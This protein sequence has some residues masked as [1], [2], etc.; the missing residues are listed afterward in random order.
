LKLKNH[1]VNRQEIIGYLYALGATAIWSGNVAIARGLFNDIPPVSLAFWRWVVAVIVTLPFGLKWLIAE[2]KLLIKHLPYLMFTALLGITLFNTLL[3]IAGHTTTAINLSLISITFPI[4][5]IL[6][7]RIFFQEQITLN[8][9][10]GIILVVSGI[11]LLITKG[12]PAKL[13]DITF[14]V[15]DVLMLIAAFV[16]ALYGIKIKQKP[17]EMNM[18]TFQFSTF[19]LGLIFLLPAYAWEY[20]TV[21]PVMFTPRIVAAI[22]YIGIFASL[23][24]FILWNKAIETIGPSKTGLAYYSM[25]LFGGTLAFLFLKEEISILHLYCVLLIVAGILI[26]NYEKRRPAESEIP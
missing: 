7:S 12:N 5:I 8:R 17:A 22:L 14:A 23:V 15:G 2:R 10:L 1:N 20:F 3:Y 18:W 24:A 6:L 25:P 21:P 9:W 11:I 26:A 19:A 4:F 13:L 16:F